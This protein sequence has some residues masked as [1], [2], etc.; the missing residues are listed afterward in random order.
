MTDHTRSRRCVRDLPPS[1]LK[2]LAGTG[3]SVY[4]ICGLSWST[5]WFSARAQLDHPG[6]TLALAGVTV[7]FGVLT[8]LHRWVASDEW[9]DRVYPALAVTLVFG[10]VF[11][12]TLGLRFAGVGRWNL[13]SGMYVVTLTFAF[14]VL[15]RGWAVSLILLIGVSYGLVLA[16]P[17]G[18]PSPG[19]QWCFLMAVAIASSVVL[20]SLVARSELLASLEREARL[21]LAEI[22]DTLEQHVETQVEEVERLN[23]LRRFLAPQV[24]EAV[25]SGAGSGAL[26]PHRRLIA[27]LFCDLRGFTHFSATSEPE[28]IVDLIES[29]YQVSVDVLSRFDATIGAF[30]GDGVMAYFGDPMPCS[31]PAGTTL[32]RGWC[33][34]RR[35]G[36]AV[37]RCQRRRS[38]ARLRDRD[39]L[40]PRDPRHDRRR[41][42]LRLHRPGFS[43]EPG[44]PAVRR[45]GERRDRPRSTRST[46]QS[47][48]M[49]TLSPAGC[50]SRA[51]S[52][53]SRPTASRRR[54]SAPTSANGSWCNGSTRATSALPHARVASA[55]HSWGA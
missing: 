52:S 34:A 11:L 18:V 35:A 36:P 20:S 45:G 43:G 55:P 22:N 51:S 41:R 28:E 10:S 9:L 17:G 37:G 3:G 42:A 38:G 47:G 13:G 29:Y 32:R 40:W 27:V 48:A 33:A 30:V 19:A 12:I 1:T 4:V 5:L 6:Q 39:R 7:A 31:D 15:K 24:A 46:Q 50:S 54:R 23:L 53:R 21:S 26:E 49:S 44:L 2:Y 8:V 14:Y 25:L 16:A